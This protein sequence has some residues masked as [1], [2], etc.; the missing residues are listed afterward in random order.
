MDDSPQKNLLNDV[1]SVVYPPTWSGDNEDRF[2]TIQLQL[3]L[4]HL[5]RSSEAVTNY[6]KRVM[7]LGGHLPEDRKSNLA[8]KILRGVALWL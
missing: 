1:H 3:W 7:L 4:E 6:V 2:I 5:F 8:I